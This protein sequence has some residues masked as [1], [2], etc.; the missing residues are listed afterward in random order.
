MFHSGYRWER[1]NGSKIQAWGKIAVFF[2]PSER[3]QFL[4]EVIGRLKKLR[5]INRVA[6]VRE[7]SGD[8]V[9]GQQKS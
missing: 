3:K 2:F 4:A 8:F 9:K 5:N 6:T 1:E 7:K